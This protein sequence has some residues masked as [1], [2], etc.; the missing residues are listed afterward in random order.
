[1]F[2]QQSIWGTKIILK[3]K[4]IKVAYHIELQPHQIII[5]LVKKMKFSLNKGKDPG[6][7]KFINQ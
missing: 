5:R 3:L 6:I 2:Q 7:I 4:I 1:M